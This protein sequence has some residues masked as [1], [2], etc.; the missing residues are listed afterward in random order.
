[1]TLAERC[2][3]IVRLI[4]EALAELPA[5]GSENTPDTPVTRADA[6]GVRDALEATTAARGA[7]E[8]RAAG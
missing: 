6:R 2:D 5:A 7:V 1:M 4:E 3:E 8:L